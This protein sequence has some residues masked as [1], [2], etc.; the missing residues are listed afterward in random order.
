MAVEG[1][2]GTLGPVLVLL[3]AG[4]VAVPL[5]RRLGLGSV[6]GYFAAGLL[7]GPF[8][9]GFFT[10]PETIL[11]IS[12][13]GV[14]MFLFVIGLEM[15]PERLWSLR[16][17]IFGLGLGQVALCAGLLTAAGIALGFSPVVAFVG[18][19]GFVLSSTAVIVQVLRERGDAATPQGQ[20]AISILLLEDLAIVP[21]LALVAFL[22]PRARTMAARRS[23][24][25][26]SPSPRS[27]L[28]S[29]PGAGS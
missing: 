25:S 8:G 6:L 15:R 1:V 24:P 28:C 4:V 19:A 3:G 12:E 17:D 10:D 26:R 18:G 7:V 9:L 22:A 27:S 11:H 14:V 20:K 2:T 16:R 5:F 21:L 29:P 23:S 13:L